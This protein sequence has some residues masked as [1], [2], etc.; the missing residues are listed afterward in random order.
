MG[1]SCLCKSC[2]QALIVELLMAQA[3]HIKTLI[4]SASKSSELIQ[5]LSRLKAS[6]LDVHCA[7]AALHRFAVC[8]ARNNSQVDVPSSLWSVLTDKMEQAK[9]PELAKLAWACGRQTICRHLF[10]V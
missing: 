6:Q 10:G 8:R 3:G 9:P 7:A 5:V 1:S 2:L 4:S